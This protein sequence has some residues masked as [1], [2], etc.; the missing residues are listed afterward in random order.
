MSEINVAILWNEQG[1]YFVSEDKKEVEGKQTELKK[2]S[3]L[4]KYY[5]QEQRIPLFED[6][7]TVELTEKGI[8]KTFFVT[9]I[10]AKMFPTQM[11]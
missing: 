4:I 10:R 5:L 3:P 6:K 9:D 11:D 8:N 1:V 2:K 7:A